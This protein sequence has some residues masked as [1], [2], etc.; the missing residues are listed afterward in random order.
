MSV[1]FF[2]GVLHLSLILYTFSG[3]DDIDKAWSKRSRELLQSAAVDKQ[4]HHGLPWGAGGY[5]YEQPAA[6]QNHVY[7]FAPPA[8]PAQQGQPPE[9]QPTL[10]PQQPDRPPSTLDIPLSQSLPMHPPAQPTPPNPSQTYVVDE[11][12]SDT[13]PFV[14]NMPSPS[15]SRTSHRGRY[16]NR[17]L[18]AHYTPPPQSSRRPHPFSTAEGQRPFS[19]SEPRRHS[20]HPSR[21]QGGPSSH[22][23]INDLSVHRTPMV[24]NLPEET[25]SVDAVSPSPSSDNHSILQRSEM[26]I[27]YRAEPDGQSSATPASLPPISIDIP[28]RG[29]WGWISPGT[30]HLDSAPGSSLSSRRGTPSPRR[31]L[32]EDPNI[33]TSERL[34]PADLPS[35]SAITR[36]TSL[37]TTFVR[38]RGSR[39]GPEFRQRSSTTSSTQVQSPQT[40]PSLPPFTFPQPHPSMLMSHIKLPSGEPSTILQDRTGSAQPANPPPPD[41]SPLHFSTLPQLV[42]PVA[43]PPALPSPSHFREGA[44][45][46]PYN[47]DPIILPSTPPPSIV[48]LSPIE[49]AQESSS[50]E[51]R[52]SIRLSLGTIGRTTSEDQSQRRYSEYT[53]EASVPGDSPDTSHRILSSSNS[54]GIRRAPTPAIIDPLLPHRL[55]VRHGSPSDE[56]ST[57][58]ATSQA[59]LGLTILHPPIPRLPASDPF[60][61]SVEFPGFSGASTAVDPAPSIPVPTPEGRDRSSRRRTP[62][63][64]SLDRDD[65]GDRDRYSTIRTRG[66]P[67]TRPLSFAGDI[68]FG[69]GS[70]STATINTITSSTMATAGSHSPPRLESV[71]ENTENLPTPVGNHSFE[72]RHALSALGLNLV[73]PRGDE[74]GGVEI[75][76][77]GIVDSD[78][79]SETSLH[80]APANFDSESRGEGEPSRLSA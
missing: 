10:P 13:S 22:P 9:T 28:V 14:P 54:P 6:F 27:Q 34:R 41:L 50:P 31:N 16:D 49:E 3:Y 55:D 47:T 25:I 36:S 23:S 12:G 26:P 43:T 71:T 69:S 30:R 24:F 29:A 46:E 61:D 44:G 72:S 19:S 2:I 17:Y 21:G 74:P 37:P 20:H 52:S 80:T 7:Q 45:G 64:R 5:L 32:L 56:L 38:R 62:S 8:A 40:T 75:D 33:G 57:G 79:S 35:S 39:S 70:N 78:S 60:S 51:R 18:S 15:M 1:L 76:G 42:P 68:V 53:N 48:Q 58:P 73:T 59:S 66:I 11:Y 65:G 77:G 4:Y 67:R 63:D